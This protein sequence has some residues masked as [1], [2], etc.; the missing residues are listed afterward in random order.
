MTDE[1]LREQLA[2]LIA[3]VTANS[4]I[5]AKM[6]EEY[7]HLYIPREERIRM[8]RDDTEVKDLRRRVEALERKMRQLDDTKKT[9]VT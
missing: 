5:V 4:E 1:T 7:G 6:K 9:V 2:K 8:R 3:K